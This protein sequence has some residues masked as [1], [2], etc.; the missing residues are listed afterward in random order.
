MRSTILQLVEKKGDLPPLPEVM[1]R[2]E[3][4]VE[5]P[6]VDIEEIALII[7]SEP[8]LAGKLLKLSNS[9]FFG[10]GREPVEDLA[11]AVLRLGLKMVLDLTFTLELPG[12]FNKVRIPNQRQFWQHSLAVAVFS[13]IISVRFQK[14]KCEPDLC[15]IS[16]L[17]HDIGVMVFS[18][19]IPDKY[20]AFIRDK[21]SEE[22]SLHSLEE[23]EF[24]INHSHLG[25]IFIKK[26]WTLK[27]EVADSV[28]G[29]HSDLS[30]I[31]NISPVC[32]VVNIANDV[33]NSFGFANKVIDSKVEDFDEEKLLEF[34]ISSNELEK[35]VE[36]TREDLESTSEI[37]YR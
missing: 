37:L 24:G 23:K 8:V 31:K 5:D 28:L 36:E 25:A 2:L 18:Y 6:N 20:S 12:L 15:Y 14:V 10:G 29:H 16:G 9:V 22:G 13:R 4:K 33:A 11:G 26:W 7:E 3:A 19:L 1:L 17:M 32:K 21:W 35:I 30:N 27:P 34:G